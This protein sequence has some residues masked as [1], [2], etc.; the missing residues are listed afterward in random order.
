MTKKS[1]EKLREINDESLV[2]EGD[3]EIISIESLT[4]LRSD[5]KR[6]SANWIL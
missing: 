3:E 6:V 1:Q 4:S 2:Y 5:W